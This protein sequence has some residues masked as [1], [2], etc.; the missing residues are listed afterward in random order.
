[1][2]CSRLDHDTG[3]RVV[4]TVL[5]GLALLA[6]G[7]GNAKRDFRVEQL[8]PLITRASE[9]RA[10]LASLLRSSRPHHARDA[11]ILRSGIV[12]LGVTMRR[13]AVLHPPQGTEAKFKR[14]TRANTVLL[15]SLSRFVDAFASG[16]LLRVR[17]A[18]QQTRAAVAAANRAQ[19][20]LQHA[21][22]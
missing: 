11:R 4:G 20:S 7:C 5:A 10:Q 6:G 22:R 2:R 3:R 8:N 18:D 13:L 21:L 16:N 14:Y 9:Q 12:A 19:T 15:A 1:V 17:R